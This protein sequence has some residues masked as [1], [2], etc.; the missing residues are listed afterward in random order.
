[1][2]KNNIKNV[3]SLLLDSRLITPVRLY[4]YN[5]KIVRCDDYVQ[6]YYYYDKKVRH[7]IKNLDI[8]SLK[9]SNF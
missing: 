7:N 5:V 8:N 3:K 4:T 1:M 2:S 9:K 6:V